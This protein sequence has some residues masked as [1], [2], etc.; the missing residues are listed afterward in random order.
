MTSPRSRCAGPVVRSDWVSHCAYYGELL[1]ENRGVL[2]TVNGV[3]TVMPGAGL[4]GLAGAGA[5]WSSLMFCGQTPDEMYFGTG[6]A[7]PAE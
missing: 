7:V 5:I 4:G 6:D 2:A 3:R 1:A